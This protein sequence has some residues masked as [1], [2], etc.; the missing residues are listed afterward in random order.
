MPRDEA[1]KFFAAANETYK[2]EL[3]DGIAD[4]E[5]SIYKTGDEFVD[6]CKGPHVAS[7]G[8]IKGFKL[9]SVAGAYWRGD[10]KK[11]MLQRIYGTAFFT[12][13][14]LDEYLKMLEEASQARSSQNSHS[15]GSFPY[16]SRHRRGRT[17]FLSSQR[18]HASKDH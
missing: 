15:A 10:E 3:I 5:V 12:Q 14:E 13:K 18:G 8:L 16:L 1:K 6:L 9:L 2:V 4:E 11:P 17:C 7:T